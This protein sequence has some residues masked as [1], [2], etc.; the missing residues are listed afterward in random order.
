MEYLHRCLIIYEA[1]Y[2]YDTIL[3]MANYINIRIENIAHIK[4][5]GIGHTI[6]RS[7][8]PWHYR[9]NINTPVCY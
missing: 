7:L 4:I 8:A 2:S 5:S 9:V 3:K 1:V 6:L